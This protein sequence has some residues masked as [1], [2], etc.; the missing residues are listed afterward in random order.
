MDAKSSN[1]DIIANVKLPRRP[2]VS[3]HMRQIGSIV[4]SPIRLGSNRQNHVPFNEMVP[5]IFK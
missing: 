2:N 5:E 3:Q 1:L 4:L